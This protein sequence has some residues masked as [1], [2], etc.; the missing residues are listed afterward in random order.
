MDPTLYRTGINVNLTPPGN[1][2]NSNPGDDDVEIF[3]NAPL[4]VKLISFTAQKR[5]T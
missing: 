4:P 3:T 1:L 5:E 2:L